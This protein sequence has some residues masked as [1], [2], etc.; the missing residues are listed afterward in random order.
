VIPPPKPGR[1]PAPHSRRRRLAIIVT[2]IIL[3]LGVGAFFGAKAYIEWRFAHVPNVVGA[4]EDSAVQ[5]LEDAGYHVT[6]GKEFDETVQQGRVIETDPT[7]GSRLTKG[8]TVRVVVSSGK[9]HYTIPGLKNA[10]P[11]S[12]SEQLL[13]LGPNMSVH[14]EREYSNC[15]KPSCVVPQNKVTRTSPP[16]GTSITSGQRITIYVSLGAPYVDVPPVAG[17]SLH[18]AKKALR[19]AHLTSTTVEQFSDQVDEGDVISADPNDQARKFGQVTLTV[20]KGPELVTVPQISRGESSGD[21]SAALQAVGLVPEIHSSDGRFFDLVRD[22]EP[23]PGTQ[24][25]RG[26]TVIL[27][28]V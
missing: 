16:A 8:H 12:A 25:P 9:R 15:R 20:S 4:S 3:L 6:V 11:D 22:V 5:R 14:F 10:D 13:G 21:A 27:T 1:E 2:I 24:V 26:S 7:P 23:G 19:R 18:A 28:V 17:K